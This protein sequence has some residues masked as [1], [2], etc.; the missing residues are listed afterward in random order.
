MA[1]FTQDWHLCT[2]FR[3]V[4]RMLASHAQAGPFFLPVQAVTVLASRYRRHLRR[5]TSNTISLARRPR[6]SA[7]EASA[8]MSDT[9]AMDGTSA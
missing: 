4:A 9:I 2:N 5:V 6:D 7:S 3:M 8:H 1:A